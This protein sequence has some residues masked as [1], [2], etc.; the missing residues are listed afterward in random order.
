MLCTMPVLLQ[1]FAKKKKGKQ[2]G[3]I[4]VIG[5]EVCLTA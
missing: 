5:I 2:S 1:T 3:K 4:Q